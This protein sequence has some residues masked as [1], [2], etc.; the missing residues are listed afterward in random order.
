MAGIADVAQL[1]GVSKSTAS[2][3]LT[4]S[5]YVSDATRARV[6]S[7]AAEPRLR[8]LDQRRQPRDRTHEHHRRR[9]AVRQPLVLRRGP[10]GNPGVAAGARARPHALRRRARHRRARADLRGLPRPQAVRRTHRRRTRAGRPRTRAAG[11]DRPPRRERGRIDRRDHRRRGRRRRRG[12]T[13]DRASARPR[14]PR[15]RLPRRRARAAL[16]ARRS[17]PV[18]R[19]SGERWRKPGSQGT[20]RTSR[21]T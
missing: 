14:P 9:H 5:G 8:R 20:R 19:L 16:G 12:A 18:R 6:R 4:G 13:G 15:H 7:A 21:P 10:R 11:R 3:A 17:A 2:R 1:A